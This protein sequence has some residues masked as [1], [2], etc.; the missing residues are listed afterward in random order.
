ML[1]I[2]VIL[3]LIICSS[4]LF[5]QDQIDTI[6]IAASEAAMQPMKMFVGMLGDRDN[7]FCQQ[8]VDDFKRCCLWSGRFEPTVAWLT[9]IP[10][11]R[12]SIQ[13]LFDQEYDC[14]VFITCD[15][16]KNDS[17][18]IW[19]LYDTIEGRMLQGKKLLAD[20]AQKTAY[21]LATQV[22]HELTHE[23][24]P[25]LSKIVYRK[26]DQKG[27]K[28]GAC[29]LVVADFDGTN[30]KIIL[31]SE[32]RILVAP[33]WTH[34][35][36][37]PAVVYSEFTTNNVRLK[38]CD[39][40]GH[41]AIIF[42]DEGTTVGVSFSPLSKEQPD[43]T[44][45]KY[46]TVN[47]KSEVI[48]CRS[49][50]IWSYQYDPIHKKAVHARIIHED[51]V[52]SHPTLLANGDILY[53]C[54]GTLKKY[55]AMMKKSQPLKV[56]GYCVAPCYSAVAHKVVYA[57]KVNGHMQ[58]FLYDVTT[59]DNQQLTYGTSTPGD[60]DYNADKTDPFWAPD[61]VH[62]VF[63]WESHDKSRIAMLNT[64]TKRYHFVT[65]DYEHCSYPAWSVNLL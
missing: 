36:Q 58:L 52:C 13:K 56:T 48:Y 10:H 59:E 3:I 23:P 16:L 32:Q 39:L 45:P 21:L 51:K 46:G 4:P 64:I 6:S 33:R 35:V 50:H 40:L 28:L 14:A 57:K 8:L 9:K 55:D 38:I 54:Q 53:A 65:S 30:P 15:N 60:L 22:L 20:E 17:T 12:S 31:K 41:S 25:F 34:D 47:K 62:V 27:K 7:K 2:R 11:K 26:R 24:Q 5:S 29:S 63:C 18:I 42:D 19:R 61:G 37:N 49:G 1:I 44:R 43:G